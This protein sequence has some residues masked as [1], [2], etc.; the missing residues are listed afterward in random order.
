MK[1]RNEGQQRN[2][3]AG[4]A[5]RQVVLRAPDKEDFECC[6]MQEHAI[7][8]GF[9]Q[10][11][12]RI[13]SMHAVAHPVELTL[14]VPKRDQHSRQDDAPLHNANQDHAWKA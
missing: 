5:G 9:N 8:V 6:R 2:V 1:M 3:C 4:R 12:E 13:D 11:A 10:Q 14:C 7:D